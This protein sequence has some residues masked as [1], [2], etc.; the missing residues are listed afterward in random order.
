MDYRALQ[1]L[2]TPMWSV[3]IGVDEDGGVVAPPTHF[4]TAM[5][6][7]GAK[8][9]LPSSPFHNTHAA[10]ANRDALLTMARVIDDAL[11]PEHQTMQ[12]DE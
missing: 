11:P 12:G 9:Y 5:T 7:L 8:P 10:R 2:W 3:P 6:V 1:T 4:A